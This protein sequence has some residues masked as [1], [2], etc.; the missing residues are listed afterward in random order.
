MAG[1]P[2]MRLPM[3][4]AKTRKGTPCQRSVVLGKTR[5]PNHGGLSTGPKTAEGRARSAEAVRAYWARRREE[6]R[7]ADLIAR[8]EARTVAYEQ[9]L[10]G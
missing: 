9:N 3:C 4:G 5:C 8:D 7:L 2:L 10:I 1:Q 6:R